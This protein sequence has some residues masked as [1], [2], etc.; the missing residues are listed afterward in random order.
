MNPIAVDSMIEFVGDRQT[1]GFLKHQLQQLECFVLT[2]RRRQYP[3]LPPH[4]LL[5]HCSTARIVLT[6][7]RLDLLLASL[8]AGNINRVQVVEQM[9]A[10]LVIDEPLVTRVEI[11]RVGWHTPL[12]LTPSKTRS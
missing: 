11:H 12:V 1:Y 7:W 8:L 5:L 2:R 3:H 4:E 6:G 9:L 10:K